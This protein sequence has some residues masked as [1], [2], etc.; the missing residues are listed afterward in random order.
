MSLRPRGY[1]ATLGWPQ[2]PADYVRFRGDNDKEAACQWRMV[3]H[4]AVR[5]LAV[6]TPWTRCALTSILH[7][8]TMFVVQAN[9]TRA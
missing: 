7:T 6:F 9:K 4:R 8:R 1:A 2:I 3:V 5:T